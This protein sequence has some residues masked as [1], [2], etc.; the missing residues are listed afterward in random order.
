MRLFEEETLGMRYLEGYTR[1]GT[2]T[3]YDWPGVGEFRAIGI[4][5]TVELLLL[6]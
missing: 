4:Y 5:C 1:L 3:R 6:V 2:N